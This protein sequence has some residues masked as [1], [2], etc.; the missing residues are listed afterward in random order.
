VR[1][2][3][4]VVLDPLAELREDRLRITKLGARDVIPLERP[5]EG[6][7]RGGDQYPVALLEGPDRLLNGVEVALTFRSPLSWRLFRSATCGSI[8]GLG[9]DG[10][11]RILIRA[12]RVS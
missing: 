2:S 12:R 7:G 6:L 10:S 11:S 4:I 1:G 9:W 3:G 8:R 5:D